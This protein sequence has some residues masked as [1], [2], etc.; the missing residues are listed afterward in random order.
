MIYD[1]V[2]FTAIT[3]AANGLIDDRM[4]GMRI[5]NS[6]QRWIATS[7]G[8]SVLNGGNVLTTHH[9]TM[10]TLPAPDTLNPG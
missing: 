1:G 9:T 3:Q 2:N 8:I 10:Y 7:E 4:R 5:D 6:D